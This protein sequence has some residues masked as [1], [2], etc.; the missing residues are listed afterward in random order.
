MELISL[1]EPPSS[2]EYS[3]WT[4]RIYSFAHLGKVLFDDKNG[5][6]RDDWKDVLIHN[7]Q[8]YDALKAG[9]LRGFVS[10]LVDSGLTKDQ[11]DLLDKNLL[12]IVSEK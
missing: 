1:T 8:D 7:I 5:I 10:W 12:E 9:Y 11:S 3:M 2:I 4:G 6:E